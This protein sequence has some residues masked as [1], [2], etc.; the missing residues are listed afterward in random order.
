MMKLTK[1]ERLLKRFRLWLFGLSND[2][3]VELAGFVFIMSLSLWWFR[4]VGR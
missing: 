2:D 1:L 4:L 3:R